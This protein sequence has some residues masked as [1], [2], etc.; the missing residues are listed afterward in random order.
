MTAADLMATRRGIRCLI[1]AE[2]AIQP[3][4]LFRPSP[5]MVWLASVGDNARRLVEESERDELA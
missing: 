1:E 4:L 5:N 2:R 3:P